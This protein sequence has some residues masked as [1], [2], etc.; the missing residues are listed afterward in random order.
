[1]KFRGCDNPGKRSETRSAF[2]K[3]G[4]NGLPARFRRQLAAEKPDG[5]VG[6]RNRPV[7]RSTQNGIFRPALRQDPSN[8][9]DR[10]LT[11]FTFC[12]SPQ[13]RATAYS[14]TAPEEP[15]KVATGDQREPVETVRID[16][17][18]NGANELP[19]I[20]YLA[21][22]RTRR[23]DTSAPSYRISPIP[24]STGFLQSPGATVVRSFRS[25]VPSS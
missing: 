1:M 22:I 7:A 5:L 3:N 12:H 2:L 8:K 16:P 18:P 23:R 21:W 19:C 20:N 25:R 4:W 6:R 10:P 15:A 14:R 9:P 13:L 17:R 11:H 24:N